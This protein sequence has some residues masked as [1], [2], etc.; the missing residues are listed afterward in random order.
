MSHTFFLLVACKLCLQISNGA[1]LQTPP[2]INF[3]GYDTKLSDGE[4]PGF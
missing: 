4:T 3:P 1:S 2:H